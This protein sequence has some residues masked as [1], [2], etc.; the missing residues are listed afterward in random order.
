MA[1]YDGRTKVGLVLQDWH[2]AH[3]ILMFLSWGLLLPSGVIMERAVGVHRCLRT[4]TVGPACDVAF[5]PV[6]PNVD[7]RRVRLPRSGRSVLQNAGAEGTA[8][9]LVQV[10]PSMPGP[11][12]TGCRPRWLALSDLPCQMLGMAVSIAGFIIAHVK[13]TNQNCL[14]HAIIGEPLE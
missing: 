14:P 2:V 5:G 9:I 3:G 12:A 6:S 13:F 10:P 4:C 8:R 7:V 1:S 11:Q